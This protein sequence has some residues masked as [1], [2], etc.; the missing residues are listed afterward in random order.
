MK[1]QN[2]LGVVLIVVVLL[3]VAATK[4]QPKPLEVVKQFDDIYVTKYNTHIKAVYV[5]GAYEPIQND[6]NFKVFD[7][8]RTMRFLNDIPQD[9]F[10]I[11]DVIEVD[12]LKWQKSERINVPPHLQHT[13]IW[14]PYPNP[15]IP[16]YEKEKESVD[17]HLTEY[18]QWVNDHPHFDM[19]PLP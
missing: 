19:P 8:E 2:I 6:F 17:T 3:T 15:P 1:R 7:K 14:I 12:G 5:I 16:V 9:K 18:S 4:I 11:G 10:E 13:T